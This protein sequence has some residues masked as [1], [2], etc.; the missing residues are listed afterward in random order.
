MTA[1]IT[2]DS[3]SE[4]PAITL[5]RMTGGLILH[6]C[7]YVAATLGIADLL[8][9]R[10]ATAAELAGTLHVDDDALHRVL[11]LLAGQGVFEEI[12]FRTFANSPLSECL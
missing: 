3:L 1:A 9:D 12:A 10:A 7:L 6:Q 11:R 8:K 5:L 2:A 4:Q